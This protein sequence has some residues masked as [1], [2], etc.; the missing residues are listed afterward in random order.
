VA[1]Q[2]GFSV[3]GRKDVYTEGCEA[4]DRNNPATS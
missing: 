4:E 3:E 2:G 1:N